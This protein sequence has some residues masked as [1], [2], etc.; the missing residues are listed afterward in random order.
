[1]TPFFSVASSIIL[2]MFIFLIIVLH[3][4][5]HCSTLSS[6][7]SRPFHSTLQDCKK[8][9]VIPQHMP[10]PIFLSLPNTIYQ[11]SVFTFHPPYPK[12]LD[13][14]G[15]PSSWLSLPVSIS[16]YQMLPV[17]VYPPSSM[18][19]FQQHIMSYSI[20]SISLFFNSNFVFPLSNSPRLL[21]PS[22][23][24]KEEEAKYICFIEYGKEP[25]IDKS[26]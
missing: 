6:T 17:A 15:V 9:R 21:N 14:I 3:P 4:V 8:E 26:S 16:T 10:Q 2:Y 25:G 1:M 5:Q 22:F 24:R 19:M 13:W 20:S 12:L 7:H 18:S 11:A 23:P